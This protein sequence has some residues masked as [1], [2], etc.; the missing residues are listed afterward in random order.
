MA[1]SRGEGSNARFKNQM[2]ST[3]RQFNLLQLL[4]HYLNIVQ[5]Q[6]DASLKELTALL[7]D[8]KKYSMY[9]RER[10]EAQAKLAHSY[11]VEE[12]GDGTWTV[13]APDKQARVIT[14]DGPIGACDCPTFTSSLIP[15]RHI[16]AFLSSK[17]QNPLMVMLL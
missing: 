13:G 8:G 17:N 1:S 3:L 7:T 16:C 12:A 5:T 9:V 15:C 14:F 4:N 6:D 2:K 11:T 10:W